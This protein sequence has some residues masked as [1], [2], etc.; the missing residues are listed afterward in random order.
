MMTHTQIIADVSSNHMGDMNIAR[1]MID[2]AA[3]VGVNWVKFQSWTADSLRKDFPEYDATLARHKKSQLSDQDHHA[4]IEHCKKAGVGFLTTCFDL[5][6]MDFLAELGLEMIKVASPDCGSV[7]LLEGLMKRFKRII[8]S[9]GMTP[10]TEVK[11]AI[12]V[13]RG[14]DV[15][16]LHCVSLYPTPL[17]QVNMKRMDWL[18]SLGVR[19]GFSD[20]SHGTEAGKMAIARGAEIL[21]KHYTFSRNLPGKDQSVSMQ[22]EDFKDLVDFAQ[23]CALMDGVANPLLSSEEERMRQIY[24]G[25]WGNNR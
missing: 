11:K 15:V 25:K 17:D 4:L 10:E 8:V 13:T 2:V 3:Q 14:H 12:D 19:V 21:E 6:R 1:A 9:T 16:F 22:P 23:K 20:H 5:N 24:V 18:R 7:K